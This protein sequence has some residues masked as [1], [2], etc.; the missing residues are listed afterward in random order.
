MPA[1]RSEPFDG[2]LQG[3]SEENLSVMR[4]LDELYIE[5]PHRG[6]RTMKDCLEDRGIRVGRERM[7]LDDA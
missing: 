7:F 5:R 6:S 2:L 3:E 4:V 1:A